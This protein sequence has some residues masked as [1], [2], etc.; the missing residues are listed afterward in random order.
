[1]GV[2]GYLLTDPKKTGSSTYLLSCLGDVTL[3]NDLDFFFTENK[4][5]TQKKEEFAEN[6]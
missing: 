5:L 6:P 4:T 1:V 2:W 3:F